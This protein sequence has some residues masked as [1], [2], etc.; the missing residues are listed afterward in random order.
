MKKTFFKTY[1]ALIIIFHIFYN[2]A[3]ISNIFIS[4]LFPQIMLS[5]VICNIY[6]LIV[7]KFLYELIKYKKNNPIKLI[8]IFVY[9]PLVI[10]I[11]LASIVSIFDN[12]TSL[13]S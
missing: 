7:V 8:A 9:L 5:C 1:F 13:V 3:I 4:L 2:I 6:S 12:M 10:L 11:F